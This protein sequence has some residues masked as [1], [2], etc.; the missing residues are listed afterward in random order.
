MPNAFGPGSDAATLVGLFANKT[1]SGED[2]AAL[3]GA[4]TSSKAFAQEAFGIPS[5]GAQ[6]D[7]PGIWDVDFYSNTYT[8][9]A[10]VFRFD[11]DI[12]LAQASRVGYLRHP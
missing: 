11:S 4:H 5:G 6:D 3:V 12:N 1:L 9:P 10:N 8:P 2:L 7:T